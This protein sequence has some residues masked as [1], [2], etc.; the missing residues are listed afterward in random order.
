MTT[1]HYDLYQLDIRNRWQ[2]IYSKLD[3]LTAR[4]NLSLELM[5]PTQRGRWMVKEVSTTTE[6]RELSLISFLR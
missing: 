6:T 5:E 4:A 3:L 1:T 2:R